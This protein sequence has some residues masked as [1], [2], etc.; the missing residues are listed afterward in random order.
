MSSDQNYANKV[1]PS[2][3][4]GPYEEQPKQPQP[5]QWWRRKGGEILPVVGTTRSGTPICEDDRGCVFKVHNLVQY[6]P[7][8]DS[9]DYQPP[10]R[11]DPGDGWRLID[12]KTDQP[13]AGDEYW[14]S[15]DCVWCWRYVA[16]FSPRTF[17]RRRIEPLVPDPGEGHRLL[18]P[19]EPLIPRDEY[20]CHD[21]WRPIAAMYVRD[22]RQLANTHYRR[23]I[24]PLKPTTRTVEVQK[25]TQ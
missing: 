7:D 3:D 15:Q 23:R 10:S 13:Q 4:W 8:C 17:Y 14:D 24:E 6:L 25:G 16:P 11:P 2:S 18:D 1:S 20:W 9:F 21:S 19:S 22:S 5:G 12:N